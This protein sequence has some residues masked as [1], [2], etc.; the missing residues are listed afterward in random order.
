MKD[1]KPKPDKPKVVIAS[2]LEI[3]LFVFTLIIIVLRA[4]YTEAPM[5]QTSQIQSAIHDTVYSLALSGGLIFSMLLLLLIRLFTGRLSFKINLMAIAFLLL[6][7]AAVISSVYAPNKRAAINASLIFLSP[8]LM[9]LLLVCLLDSHVKIKILLI[10]IAS[11]GIVSSWQSAEQFFISNNAIIEQYKENPYA[12]LDPLGIRL[13]SLNHILLEHRILSKDVR[14]CFTTGN[15]AGS[16]AILAAFAAVAMLAELL[17]TRKSFPSSTGNRGLAAIMILIIL[18]GLALTRSK[19]AIGAFLIALAVF[20]ML[21]L[22]KKQ[23]VFKNTILACVIAA[24][25]IL[26]PLAAWYGLKHNRLPGGNSMLV[27]WQ[28]WR[29]SAQMAADHSLTGIGPGNFVYAYHQY[30]PPSAP[31]TVSDPHCFIL[32]ILTQYGPLGLLAFLLFVL[33]PMWRSSLVPSNAL[34]KPTG[35]GFIKLAL[36]CTLVPTA[37]MLALRPALLPQSHAITLDEKIY[38]LFNDFIAPAAAL[39]VGFALFIKSIQTIP[40]NPDG[41]EA[42]EKNAFALQNTNLTAIALFCGLLGVLIHNLVDFAIFEPGVFTT[43]CAV[44]ACLI[45]LCYQA[46]SRPKPMPA[47]AW[48]KITAIAGAAAIGFAYFNYAL[49]PVSKSTSK[50]AK[51]L[52]AVSAARLN[53][54]H[55]LLTIATHD[56]PLSPE[57]PIT[58]ARLYLDYFSS[59]GV[60]RSDL[61]YETEKALS[62]AIPR[63]PADYK[64]FDL[65][66]ELY[67]LRAQDEPE[68]KEQW[69]MQAFD[70]ESTAVSLF[71]GSGEI[72]FKLAQIADELGQTDSALENYQKA[73]IIEDGFRE[74]FRTMY[75]GRDIFSRLGEGKYIFAKQRIEEL[76]D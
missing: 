75:P 68:E 37:V 21:V 44:L 61:F 76:S 53:L 69:L 39:V 72:H 57:A 71:P 52:Y 4:T 51:A 60:S 17:K 74:Q 14:G 66:A 33:V 29:A 22:S 43:F 28:Y 20:A 40:N 65:L 38:V 16:F 42:A 8:M 31:E 18:F 59:P 27:R 5:P 58:N 50:I 55:D 46:Q 26:I 3:L 24:V 41:R 32:N 6:L 23:K 19:G 30:K 12:I 1:A 35:R 70:A 67:S 45:A 9:V 47:P 62:A 64:I 73:V 11:L 54:A 63:N 13:N 2:L 10:V 15:S 25:C 36:F 49:L 34:E 7:I 56:D 48:L